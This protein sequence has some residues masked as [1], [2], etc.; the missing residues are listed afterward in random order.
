M[1]GV[2]GVRAARGVRGV[3]GVVGVRGELPR[4]LR[5]GDPSMLKS[6]FPTLVRASVAVLVPREGLFSFSSSQNF[7]GESNFDILYAHSVLISKLNL[8][9]NLFLSR[10]YCSAIIRFVSSL[11]GVPN[12]HLQLP[13][14]LLGELVTFL[15]EAILMGISNFFCFGVLLPDIIRFIKYGKNART[16]RQ[17]KTDWFARNI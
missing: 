16:S 1:R 13:R 8:F 15:N 5:D 9:M 10:E 14:L 6:V 11:S 3:R 7:T 17:V 12:K 4:L 2:R